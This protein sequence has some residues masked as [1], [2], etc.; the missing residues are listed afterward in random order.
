MSLIE[1]ILLIMGISLV[2]Y[3]I[4]LILVL[5]I[6]YRLIR[7]YPVVALFLLLILIAI[8]IVGSLN[9]VTIAPALATLISSALLIM[10]QYKRLKRGLKK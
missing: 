2:I 4:I 3:F 8:G 1:I 7:K 9:P 6:I 10:S 5:Y